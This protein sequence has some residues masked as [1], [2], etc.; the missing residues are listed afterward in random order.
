MFKKKT[1]KNVNGF[2]VA[3]P[4]K[5]F[6]YIQENFSSHQQ[7]L[8]VIYNKDFP[9]HQKLLIKYKKFIPHMT[10]LKF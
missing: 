6:G 8:L 5:P 9:H 4:S 2:V 10:F 7:K 3:L 1:K